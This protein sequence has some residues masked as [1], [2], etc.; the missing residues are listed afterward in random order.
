MKSVPHL[1]QGQRPEARHELHD[2]RDYGDERERG[3]RQ[4]EDHHEG[5]AEDAAPHRSLA[6]RVQ[7][8]SLQSR[9]RQGRLQINIHDEFLMIGLLTSHSFI[10]H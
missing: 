5:V 1:L 4:Q 6:R 3:Q 7:C 8:L 2:V 10:T 9:V